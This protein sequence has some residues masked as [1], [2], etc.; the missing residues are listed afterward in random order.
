MATLFFPHKKKDIQ[1]LEKVQNNF[2]RKI[3]LISENSA[4]L[5]QFFRFP[6]A[7]CRNRTLKLDSLVSHRKLNDVCMVYKILA[8]SLKTDVSKF[9][10]LVHS[11]TRGCSEKISFGTPKTSIRSH[12]FTCRAGSCYTSLKISNT[13]LP[14][15]FKAF[16]RKFRKRLCSF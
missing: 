3:F 2:T 13:P 10:R 9:F 15:S 11:R 6:G 14:H 5:S 8:G 1:L 7:L 12:S 16:R 4:C